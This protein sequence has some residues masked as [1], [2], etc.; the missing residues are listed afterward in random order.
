MTAISGLVGFLPLVIASDGAMSRWSL[1]TAILGG[2]LISNGV[3]FI[4]RP[5]FVC[6]D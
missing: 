6:A 5:G 3:K 1:G 4:S 2:Y